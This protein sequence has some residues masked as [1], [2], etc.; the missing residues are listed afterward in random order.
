MRNHLARRG[1]IWWARLVV[2]A[3]LR[4]AAR[5]R[6]FTKSTRTH[7]L[8]VAKL[9]AA[10]MIADWRK[11]LMRLEAHAM[12]SVVLKLLEPAPALAIGSTISIDH[13]SQLGIERTAVLRLWRLEQFA[14][15]VA[16]PLDAH[17]RRLNGCTRLAQRDRRESQIL[18]SRLI[19]CRTEAR[20]QGRKRRNSVLWPPPSRWSA[21]F[22]IAHPLPCPP[23]RPFWCEV[24]A[25]LT[26]PLGLS[27]S[28]H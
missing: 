9:V 22:A 12:N 14:S 3:R 21:Q 11:Q 10:V 18:V 26:L 2:P 27:L 13:A 8:H 6:E 7:E 16:L 19:T 15:W 25:T 1:G 17:R 5:R 20:L 23:R 24:V 28:G 4:K